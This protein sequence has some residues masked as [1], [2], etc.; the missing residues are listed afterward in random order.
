MKSPAEIGREMFL[1]GTFEDYD[2]DVI[3]SVLQASD[4]LYY[5]DDSPFLEDNEYDALRLYA[6]RLNPSH[7]YFTGVGS[8]VRGGKVKLPHEM[9]SLDQVEI[10]DIA[11]WVG[12][13][14]LQDEEVV[15]TDKL[16]GTSAMEI[17]DE[18]GCLQ[19]AYSRGN[20][21]EGAD[22][23]RHMKNF[24]CN[25]ISTGKAMDVRGEVIF[26][27]TAFPM[28]QEAVV[29]HSGRTY[30]N[31]RN[32]V[33]GIMNRKDNKKYANLIFSH[34]HF[35]AYEILNFEGSKLEMLEAL[36]EAGYLVPHYE[37]FKGSELTDEMLAKYLN[38][39]REETDYEIDGIVI[40][41]NSSRARDRMNPTRDTLNPAYS[42]KYKVADASNQAIATVKSVTWN[43]SK[44][45]YLKPQV[46]LEPVDLVGVTIS[47]ATGFNA[48]FIYENGIGPG[49][50]V[51][52]TRSGDVIPFIQG[53]VEKVEAQMPTEEWEWNETGVDAIVINPEQHDE[54]AIQ[55]TVDFF[56]SIEAPHLKE[57]TVRQMFE[58]NNYN[59][60]THAILSMLNY[61]WPHWV[62]CIG[63]N[64]RKIFDGLE[65]KMSNMELH[66]L[67]GSSPFFGRGVGKRKFKK[68]LTGLGVQSINEL[69][70]I[71]KAQIT[72]VEGFEDKTATKI[73][74]GI[75]S[76]MK[77]TA[78]INNLNLVVATVAAGGVMEGEK[79]AFTGF[80]DKDLQAQVEAEGG[81]MQ[82]A[83]SGKTTILIAKNPNSTS[84]KMKKARDN[85]TRIMGVDEFRE[86]MS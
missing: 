36:K 63:A 83:V 14:S 53:V 47:N 84:G 9:G 40:D 80:R 85:G 44:H 41:V 11:D 43:I 66:V 1:L 46:N 71:N 42:V 32:M 3:L 20:G 21:T 6:N 50:K 78:A 12:N 26:T 30:K 74:R 61:D 17:R 56:S 62:N 22:I 13:W 86:M 39:R 77:F 82:S 29:N 19:I 69:L 27:K 31:A 51:S 5:N 64:G 49:A 73:I 70:L 58:L 55:Q 60:S 79:I 34:I 52:L 48:Q 54:I 75:D 23:T 76:F 38:R 8:D 15:I 65:A 57:G 45:G 72:S 68:L 59:D 4:D 35:V 37:T 10:G 33:A 67:A 16:D 28:V 2:F 81:T 7:V 24:K 18:D 25:P